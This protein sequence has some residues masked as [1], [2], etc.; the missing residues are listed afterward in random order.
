MGSALFYLCIPFSAAATN[1]V[2]TFRCSM[3]NL[4]TSPRAC[5]QPALDEGP[6]LY[7]IKSLSLYE[8]QLLPCICMWVPQLVSQL[9]SRQ[10]PLDPSAPLLHSQ[11]GTDNATPMQQS[12][13]CKSEL[14]AASS[15]PGPVSNR[16]EPIG[17][18]TYQM[19]E[20]Y[21][22]QNASATA[23]DLL[24]LCPHNNCR[25]CSLGQS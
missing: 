23:D 16:F 25:F 12:H 15:S 19:L 18:L 7:N 20:L 21:V 10:Q 14:A 9:Q 11:A 3:L 8:Q 24:C 5:F 6:C 1:M 17:D 2:L 13:L 4:F 22:G